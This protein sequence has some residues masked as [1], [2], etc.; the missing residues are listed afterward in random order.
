MTAS[1]SIRLLR[2]SLLSSLLLLAAC[3]G[4]GSDDDAP[5]IST[6][7]P[8]NPAGIW[9][10]TTAIPGSTPPANTLALV[11]EDGNTLAILPLQSFPPNPSAPVIY[12][13]LDGNLC[14]QAS[15]DSTIFA[16]PPNM[17]VMPYQARLVGQISQNQFTGTLTAQG[18]TGQY[19]VSMTAQTALYQRPLSTTASTGRTLA[20]TY[21]NT[22]RFT[23]VGGSPIDLV[24]TYNIDS[25]GALTG[26]ISA[27][28]NCALSGQIAIPNAN[29][30]MFRIANLQV[31]GC[32]GGTPFLSGTY[33]VLGELGDD[34]A[35]PTT[36]DNRLVL[37]A[38]RT[39]PLGTGF[40]PVTT[41]VK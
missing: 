35:R 17:G 13:V 32:V 7:L 40:W 18:F 2:S 30:N 12:Y 26:T 22:F 31:T 11:A 24:H 20:G 3:G 41:L 34:P 10:G 33:R 9:G 38:S 36:S 19:A 4:G 15:I 21:T 1:I 39:D 29:R 37:I 6:S 27:P 8:V 14:C 25:A 16:V 5:P 23:P 28:A